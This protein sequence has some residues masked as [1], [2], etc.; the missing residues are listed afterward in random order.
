MEM[1][2]VLVPVQGSDLAVV[3][4]GEDEDGNIGSGSEELIGTFCFVPGDTLNWLGKIPDQSY[5][6][7][8]DACWMSAIPTWSYY[9]SF[10]IL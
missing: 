8:C 3:M 2:N 6:D 7:V 9:D 1:M 10:I 5:T 4:I